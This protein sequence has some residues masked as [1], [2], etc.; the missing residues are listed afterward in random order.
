[1]VSRTELKLKAVAAD[2]EARFHVKT[3]VVPADFSRMNT[4][5]W[6]A[7]AAVVGSVP[8]GVL[9]NSAGRTRRKESKAD[10]YPE[11]TC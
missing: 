2:L 1:M 8:V 4:A 3:K 6:D 10:K 9:I 5:A 11:N 7:I